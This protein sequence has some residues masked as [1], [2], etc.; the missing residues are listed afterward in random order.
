MVR[1]K[2]TATIIY[3]EFPDII[4][5]EYDGQL[6]EG[7]PDKDPRTRDRFNQVYSTYIVPCQGQMATCVLVTHA[8]LIQYMMCR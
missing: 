2:E 1:A 3:G 8:N 6:T 5:L 4:T 7:N